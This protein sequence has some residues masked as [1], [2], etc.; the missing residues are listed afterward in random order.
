M[1][2]YSKCAKRVICEKCRREHLD[3]H[4]AQFIYELKNLKDIHSFNKVEKLKEI[5]IKEKFRQKGVI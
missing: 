3:I 2:C 1:C 5:L 4:P